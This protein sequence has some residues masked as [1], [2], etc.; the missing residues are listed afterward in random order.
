GQ[1]ERMRQIDR[2][3]ATGSVVGRRLWY[4]NRLGQTLTVVEGKPTF[5][6]GSPTS[7]TDRDARMELLHPG[8]IPRSFAVGTTEVT[9]EQF[10]RF[11]PSHRPSK[12]TTSRDCP[13]NFVRWYDAAAYCNWLSEREEIPKGQWCYLPNDKGEYAEGMK[14]APDHLNLSGYRLPSEAE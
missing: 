13:V 6:M 9:L 4:V 14:P 10:A 11:R 12:F 3:L 2:S 1:G 7:E 8:T 5:P